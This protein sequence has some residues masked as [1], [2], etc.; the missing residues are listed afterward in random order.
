MN[1]VIG[2]PLDR[3]DGPLKVTGQARYAAEF[4]PPNLAYAVTVQSTISKGV[5][6][7]LDPSR[8]E[9]APGVLAVITHANAMRLHPPKSDSHVMLGEKNLLPLQGREIFY[10]GQHIAVVVAETFEQAEAA[11]RLIDVAYAAKKPVVEIEDTISKAYRPK[12]SMKRELQTTRGDFAGAIQSAPVVLSQTYETPVYHHNPMEPH[13]TV[14]EW[15]GG[16]LTIYDATQGVLGSRAAI[17][18]ML[19]LPNKQVHLICPFVGGGFG[20]KG[21]TWPHSVLAPLAAKAVGRPVKLVLDRQQ[22]FTCNGHR[23]RTIQEISLG[24]DTGGRLV[25]LRH[26][27]V[28][29]TSFVDEFVETCGLATRILYACPNAE[30]SHELVKLNKGTPTPT[31][32]PGEA[33]GTFAIESAMD[34][35]AWRLRIDPVQ[36]RIINHADANPQD[37]KAWS[38]KYLKE[39]YQR[40]MEA[41]GWSERRAEPASLRDGDYLV[42][43]GMA[44]S[45]YPANRQPASAKVQIFPD[46]RAV[47]MCCTQDIGT[48]TYTIMTQIAAEELGL[49]VEKIDF[50]LGDSFLPEGPVS[51]GSQTTASVGP[52]VRAAAMLARQKA[53]QLASA[54]TRSPLYQ[55][56]EENIACENGRLFRKDATGQGETYGDLLQRQKLPVLEAEAR[57]D[58]STRENS[59]SK[60]KEPAPGQTPDAVA[61][62]EA[63]DRSQ[64]A[65]QS[66]GAQFVKVLVDPLLGQTRVAKACLVMD[67]GRIMNLKMATNQLMG[68]MIFGL[69]MA[70][71]EGSTYDSNSGRIVTRDLANYLVPVHADIPEIEVQFIGKPDPLISPLGARG[72]GEIGITGAAAAIANAVFNATG[73]RVRQLPITPDKLIESPVPASQ[74][75]Y[76]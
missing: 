47:A 24:A 65:F 31:R 50:E 6:S 18:E 46:G 17:A 40:G 25:A 67:V 48:G 62:D 76:L 8:A 34:E 68:G 15:N 27:T 53:I 33:T 7:R 74:F 13:A 12:E 63:I 38:S 60:K 42:G 71:M 14:A 57:I 45:I 5:I 75:S 26:A 11:A 72:I 1:E 37:G 66:F 69:G 23:A 41:I 61:R 22:M 35:L 3:V 16:N 2:K 54:D 32:A 59:V 52:V 21:F 73:K 64:A 4:S 58:V 19:G 39:C 9:A 30:I 49:P 43:Y 29:E 10:N 36:L 28:T 20:C 55:Q 51:G 70:L 44:T 56:P